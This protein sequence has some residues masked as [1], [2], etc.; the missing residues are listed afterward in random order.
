MKIN[1]EKP[2]ATK[3]VL[4]LDRNPY[5]TFS[6]PSSC[7]AVGAKWQDYFKS[8]VLYEVSSLNDIDDGEVEKLTEPIAEVR[9]DNLNSLYEFLT[10]LKES[11][12][13]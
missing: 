7:G 12:A 9:K 2:K 1:Y 10:A 6:D 5:V 3:D 13:F 4:D 8:L 11:G